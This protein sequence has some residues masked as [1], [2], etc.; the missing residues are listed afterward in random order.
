[1]SFNFNEVPNLEFYRLKRKWVLKVLCKITICNMSL[2]NSEKKNII[3]NL[4]L[5]IYMY[6]LSF[7]EF[8]KNNKIQ[9]KLGQVLW[10]A[11]TIISIP[12]M[13]THHTRLVIAQ[14]TNIMYCVITYNACSMFYVNICTVIRFVCTD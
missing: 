11:P 9:L 12:T 5:G 8:S 7:A 14:L 2:S 13:L 3:V 6:V 1:M 10:G 4:I